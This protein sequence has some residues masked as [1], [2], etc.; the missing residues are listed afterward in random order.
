MRGRLASFLA[1]GVLV[2][3]CGP[4]ASE[5]GSDA[6]PSASTVASTDPALLTVAATANIFGAG[7][8]LMPQPAG[9]GGGTEPPLYRLPSGTGRTVHFEDVAGTVI[10]IVDVGLENGPEGAGGGRT[11]IESTGGIS[12]IVHDTNTMFL[13]GVFLTDDEPA[14]PAPERLDV[15]DESFTSLAPQIAQ[16]F[17]IGDGSGHKYTVPDDATRLFLGFADANR[18][19]GEVGFYGNNTGSV[20]ARVVVE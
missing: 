11:D 15:T 7:H 2:T 3:G 20:E 9:G 12:G 1:I 16:V 4:S 17:L 6:S 14:D 13:V 19:V 10:P 18:F 8:E 5:R